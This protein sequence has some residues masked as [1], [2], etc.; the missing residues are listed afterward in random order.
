MPLTII[1]EDNPPSKLLK[2]NTKVELKYIM[3]TF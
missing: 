2:I 1:R 3:A